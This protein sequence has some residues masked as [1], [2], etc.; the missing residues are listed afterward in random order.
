MRYPQFS[1]FIGI[2]HEINPAVGDPPWV[3]KPPFINQRKTIVVSSYIPL[4]H[5]Q[6]IMCVNLAT[7]SANLVVIGVSMIL[8]YWS[9][10]QGWWRS[11]VINKDDGPLPKKKKPCVH[12][13]DSMTG[14]IKMIHPPLTWQW[15]IR[16]LRTDWHLCMYVCMY[17]CIYICVCVCGANYNDSLTWNLR[18]FWDDSSIKTM[19][20]GFGRSEVVMK[21]THIY[22]FIYLFT[23]ISHSWS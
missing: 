20:P 6:A 14:W 7:F 11:V 10:I 15:T 2:F 22:I 23:Y 16:H 9:L 3:W 5:T 19:I 21:F 8:N 13:F 18:P 1:S 17:V 4:N 12:H